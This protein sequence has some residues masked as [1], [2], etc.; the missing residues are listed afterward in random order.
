ML[1]QMHVITI[2]QWWKEVVLHKRGLLKTLCCYFFMYLQTRAVELL[3]KCNITLIDVRYGCIL[4]R[5]DYLRTNF[6][7]TIVPYLT[8]TSVILLIYIYT[9]YSIY[10]YIYSIYIYIMVHFNIYYI[11][12]NV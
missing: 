1:D 12:V 10:I 11:L 7:I 8:S 4:A 5:C 3:Y 9:I 6:V 2:T